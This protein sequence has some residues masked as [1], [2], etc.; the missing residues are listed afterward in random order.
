LSK[1]AR[2]GK[3]RNLSNI[4]V[5]RCKDFHFTS[6]DDLR[7]GSM[8]C[9][10][11]GEVTGGKRGP[12]KKKTADPDGILAKLVSVK[13]EE[14]NYKGAVRLISSEDTPALRSV[15]GLQMLL[16]KHPPA[17]KDRSMP[18][19]PTILQPCTE[20][21]TSAVW[22]AVKSFPPG[23]SGGP[24]GLSPQHLKDLLSVEGSE[25]GLLQSLS[26]LINLI[27]LGKVPSFIQPFFFGGR[28]IAL[29]KKG[30]GI[31]PIVVGLTLRR[32][33]SKLVNGSASEKL[34]PLLAPLQ[35]GVGVRGGMEAAVH[36][37]RMYCDKISKS[38]RILT[39]L[40][41]SNAFNSLRRD[42][43]LKASLDA[44]PEWYPFLHS[45]YAGTSHLFW[46]S[47]IIDSSE[48]VQQGDPVGPLLFCLTVHILLSSC[49]CEFKVGYLDDF[50]LGD[51]PVTVASEVARLEEGA[52]NLGL[53]LN[54][55]KCEVISAHASSAL[56]P[57][58][59]N[60]I[61]VEV[62]HGILLGS[63][64][65]SRGSMD[66]LLEARILGLQVASSRLRLLQA[67][68]ALII[69]KN[70]MSL[71]S[72]LHILRSAP[73][74]GHPSLRKFDE[75]LRENLSLVLNVALDDFQWL[76]A[77]LPV[78][79][80]GLGI[81]SAVH[82]APSAFLASANTSAPLISAMLSASGLNVADLDTTSSLQRWTSLGG[83]DPKSVL[84]PGSQRSWD[85]Q[86]VSH[87]RDFLLDNLT[88]DVA[89]ARLK[90]V[91]APH[92]G[93]WLHALPLTAAGLRMSDEEVRIAAGLRLGSSLCAPH[94]CRCGILVN[95]LGHHGLS[96]QMSAGRQMRHRLIN[97][98]IWRA[99]GRAQIASNRE[100]QGL[101]AGSPLRP[102]GASLIPWANGRRVAWDA[103]TPDTL[104]G[105]H[106]AA[107]SGI[108]GAA[109]SSAARLKSRK[110]DELTRT[111]I[112]VPVAV[113]TLG[114]WCQEGLNWMV[115]IGRRMTRTTGDLRE[116][117][118]L[119]QRLSVAVQKGNAAS[120]RGTLPNQIL[121]DED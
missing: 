46:G 6:D 99:L 115:E 54:F 103:T 100:P 68:D 59:E 104:A 61:R 106:L 5:K 8:G 76:Q 21:P 105:S 55:N 25:G 86:V 77:S 57:H 64:L 40:D 97:D 3:S 16:D 93:D 63:P 33:S 66:E 109:A 26:S 4:I 47:S 9:D 1:P 119:L 60:F 102:D 51:E 118:F 12:V 78:R 38:D 65:S 48:G 84:I 70:S 41:F 112:F 35:V 27:T 13:L 91:M 107:T 17:H 72:L 110:Y 82:V 117:F 31:R 83:V 10:T 7:A 22:S 11:Q 111:H 15:E 75:V 95:A 120:I 49:R 67:H 20:F 56:P 30:G 80:G 50:T 18:A 96:C 45:A 58:L 73:C 29:N 53:T 114:A 44:I 71:P 32:L 43:I 19:A 23:S 2:G 90:A 87:S 108:A 113:E 94:T 28:L 24:D 89:Q 39:K 85:A 92:S 121:D 81:R 79:E 36:A 74:S 88:D 42:A 62:D 14:G 52:L 101:I 34:A 98:I 37:T 116:T 69:L